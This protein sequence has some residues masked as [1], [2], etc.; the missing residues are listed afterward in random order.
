MAAEGRWLKVTEVPARPV[1]KSRKAQKPFLIIV[2]KKI[3]RLAVERNRLKRLVREAFRLKPPVV[4]EGKTYLVKVFR[5][6]EKPGLDDMV[7]QLKK[8]I[9]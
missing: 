3:V 1:S 2:P 4:S 6:P 7:Y 8:E 5:R 9:N